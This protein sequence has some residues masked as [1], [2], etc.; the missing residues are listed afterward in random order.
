MPRRARITLPGIPHHIIQRGNNRHACFFAD[1]D[2][3]FYLNWLGQYA[4]ESRCDI[5]AYV[6]MTNHVHMLLTPHTAHGVGSLMKR[7]GQRYVQYINRTYR[8]SGTLWEGRF[9]SCLTQ[10]EEYVLSCYRYIELNPIRAKMVAHPAEYPWSSYGA[11]AQG[12]ESN[13]LTPH[14]AYQT[15]GFTEE[16]RR[17]AYNDLFRYHLEDGLIDQIRTATNGNYVLGNQH[18]Q[19]QIEIALRRRVIPGILGRPRLNKE[20]DTLDMF[21]D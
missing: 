14:N 8:R 7:L 20:N 11:N 5:H 17:S 15:L 21:S 4:R 19:K 10:D 9:R 3:R 6:L 16:S 2:Y 18:F 13:L 1:D 12:E